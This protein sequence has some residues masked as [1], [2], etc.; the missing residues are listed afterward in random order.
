MFKDSKRIGYAETTIGL[1]TR[2][3]GKLASDSG[4][5]IEG[6]FQGEIECTGDVIVGEY[7]IAR[8]GIA[9]QDLIV[10][11]KVFG[12]VNVKGRLTIAASGQLHGNVLAHSI[13]VQDGGIY[14]GHC[15]MERQTESKP[16]QLQ[17]HDPAQPA[18]QPAK[19]VPAKEKS[20]Q[21]G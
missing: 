6:E 17:E 8:A 15:R 9:A 14:N 20:R 11:G 18:P 12:D 5:R 16:R 4:I 13:L 10:A 19:E 2:A 21:A 1:G 3:E 7:G